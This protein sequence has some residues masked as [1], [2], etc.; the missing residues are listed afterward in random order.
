M[1]MTL[2]FSRDDNAKI[3]QLTKKVGDGFGIKDL[4][5]VFLEMKV[6][7]SKEKVSPY[8]LT[9]IPIGGIFF[10]I[11]LASNCVQSF[12]FL[13][14]VCFEYKNGIF[15]DATTFCVSQDF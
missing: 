11:P 15:S 10:V 5:K 6:A 1:L 12:Y 2:F 14:K 4:G 8:L 3:I 13:N 7:R 9:F